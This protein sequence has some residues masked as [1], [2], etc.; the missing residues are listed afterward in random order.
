MTQKQLTDKELLEEAS[1]RDYSGKQYW[2]HHLCFEAQA[3][4]TVRIADAAEGI[5]DMLDELL[6]KMRSE[7]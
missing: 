1:H 6:V 3:R 7:K 5:C 4:A 2:R